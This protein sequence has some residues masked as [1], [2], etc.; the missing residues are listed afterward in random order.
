MM[1]DGNKDCD[2][3]VWVADPINYLSDDI[4]ILECYACGKQSNKADLESVIEK[5]GEQV[6]VLVGFPDRIER[7]IILHLSL[8]RYGQNR[9][10][11][12]SKVHESETRRH[13]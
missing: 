13:D 7:E 12:R 4:F 6:N 11:K 8:A 5:T 3:D 10:E 2:H 9:T 1:S